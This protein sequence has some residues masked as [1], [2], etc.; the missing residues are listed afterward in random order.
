[1]AYYI[2]SEKIAVIIDPLR[3][4]QPYYSLAEQRGA[5]IKYVFLT[6]FHA[7]FV[8]GHLELMNKCGAKIVLGPK[9]EAKFEMYVAKEGEHIQVGKCS[10]EVL[11]TPGHTL[12]SSCFVLHDSV[13]KKPFCIF[14]GDTLFLGEVGRPD[15]AV[16]SSTTKEDLAGMMYDSL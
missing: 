2:E 4:T 3:D 1:M 13:Q 6:H 11:H 9:A 10:L 8:A 7:D 15:L 16:S 12:E 5:S 14:T